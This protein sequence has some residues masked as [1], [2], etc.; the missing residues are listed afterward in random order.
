[1]ET[2]IKELTELFYTHGL[3][4]FQRIRDQRPTDHFYCFG[5]LTS[6]EFAYIY[7]TASSYEG[8]EQVANEYKLKEQ[9]KEKSLDELKKMFK[10]SALDSPIHREHGEILEPL[11]DVMNQ[12]SGDLY[13]IDVDEDWTEFNEY[14]VKV[15]NVI[16]DSL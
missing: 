12:I 15:E 14:V 9:H 5:F 10:W 2:D 11:Q 3:K 6:C 7:S 16:A 13:A 4:S 1:M 8:L